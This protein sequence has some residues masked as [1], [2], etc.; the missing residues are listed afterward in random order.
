MRGGT[1]SFKHY[2]SRGDVIAESDTTGASTWRAQYDAYGTRSHESGTASADRQRS[3][4]KDEDPSG[5]RND[6]HRYYDLD[7]EIYVTADPAGFVDGPNVY[8]Y[9]V[10]NPWSKFDPNGLW[11]WRGLAKGI[12]IGVAGVAVGVV[13]GAVIVGTGGLAAGAIAYAA[14]ASAITTVGAAAT[15]MTVT[16]GGL[17]AYGGFAT[18]QKIYEAGSGRAWAANGNGARLSE[19]QQ[20][21]AAG[22]ALVGVA[23][24][25]TPFAAEK[26]TKPA[27]SALGGKSAAETNVQS[28]DAA[29]REGWQMQP[30]QQA[31][32]EAAKTTP[33]GSTR[34]IDIP[35][36][37]NGAYFGMLENGKGYVGKGPP[38][39]ARTSLRAKSRQEKSP[40]DDIAHYPKPDDAAAFAKEAELI[41]DLGGIGAPNLLNKINS[42]GKK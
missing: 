16:A 38:G 30:E 31:A 8:C 19:D 3:N 5:L 32:Q 24:I 39:R 2:D 14:G 1:P 42:P 40:V 7:A 28:A 4:T 12:A 10:Q 23:A 41:E 26:L 27:P 18:G 29:N 22:E 17:A 36:A 15:T 35:D 25:A 13:A 33:V 6:H 11:T 37:D 20:S 34:H 21:Q 9:V